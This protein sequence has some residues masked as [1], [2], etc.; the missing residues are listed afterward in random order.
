MNRSIVRVFALVVVLFAV[1]V[2]FTSRWTVFDA[3]AL[4]DNAKN[5]RALIQQLKIPRGAILADDGTVLA[6]SV[7]GKDGV[8]VRRYPQAGLFAQTIGY[9]YVDQ[10]AGL[11]RYR[12]DALTG[13]KSEFGT[14]VS[15]LQGRKRRGDTV[16]TTLDPK[17]QRVA[18]AALAGRAGSVVALDP[19]T[20]AVKVMASVP[21]FDPSTI[22]AGKGASLN[23]Q[24]G[25][26]LLNRAT[27]AGYPPG[28]T[29]KM[30][31][32][33][34]AIDSG[35]YTPQSVVDGKS[36]ITVSGVPLANDNNESFGRID[37]TTALTHS[38]NTVWAQ[39]AE[40]L[41]RGTMADYMKRFGFYSEP[42]LDYPGDQMVP[43]GEFRAGTTQL[44]D[45][46][47]GL[48]DVGRMGIGQD[49][50]RVTPLQMAMVGS[51]IANGGVLMRPHLTD[52]IVDPDGRTV[53]RI[54]PETIRRVM[55][56]ST[57]AEVTA[58]MEHVVQEGT[59]T[60][61]ALQGIRVAGK[62]GTAQIDMSKGI[63]QPWFVAFAPVDHPRIVVA[64]TVERSVGG[65]GGTVAAPIAKQVMEA[66]LNG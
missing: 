6:R 22:V 1:L 60:A 30:L 5:P 48:I 16:I 38:V 9:A 19:R 61:A 29:F 40:R 62:T 42:S 55:K 23:S 12:N 64:V 8:Y 3:K 66:L 65:F 31:T 7:L 44:L 34:A 27:Q 51:A 33:V 56:P 11:E 14:I 63:V 58:M 20:G 59:G 35:A 13:A 50:L 45:P 10:L 32:A 17:A 15:E 21:G 43:S 53:E 18:L 39:V 46:T 4:R 47:S 25:S 28:S 37:L 57:A 52:R 36:P 24:Q 54:S 26:P 41:G 49:K 2:A